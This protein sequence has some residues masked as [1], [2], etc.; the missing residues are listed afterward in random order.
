MKL[1]NLTFCSGTYPRKWSLS[2]LCP[3][4]KA[5]S[6][7]KPE[8]YRGI[9]IN[10]SIGKFFNSILNKRLDI[11]RD[12][13]NIIHPCQVGFSK[14]SRTSDYM[15]VLK[16]IL[17]KYTNRKGEK[18]YACFVDFKKAFDRVIHCG[19][20]Y[21]LLENNISGKFYSALKDIYSKND[22]SVKV[23]NVLTPSFSSLVGVRQGRGCSKSELI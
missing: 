3:I 15:F 14:K 16:T 8:N 9:A 5:G 6:P 4:F 11:H 13:N 10:S 21:E 18:I 2:D 12:K 20:K 7:S 17:D 1:F 22:M 19:I 23:G